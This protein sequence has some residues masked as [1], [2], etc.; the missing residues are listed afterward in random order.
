MAKHDEFRPAYIGYWF[1]C[2]SGVPHCGVTCVN[3]PKDM[4][5]ALPEFNCHVSLRDT[6]SLQSKMKPAT[7]V[8][9][10]AAV[11]AVCI[12]SPDAS[13]IEL[14]PKEYPYWCGTLSSFPKVLEKAKDDFNGPIWEKALEMMDDVKDKTSLERVAKLYD[15][16]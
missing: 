12:T 1:N 4:L 14:L 7:K 8:A 9:N 5:R 2:Q 6:D 11:G 13:V 15:Y 3:D 16:L 10:A